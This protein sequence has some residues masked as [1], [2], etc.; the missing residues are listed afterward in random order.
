M[1]VADLEQQKVVPIGGGGFERSASGV[2]EQPLVTRYL[3]NSRLTASQ[4]A[5]RLAL[6]P[7]TRAIVGVLARSRDQVDR[8]PS[9][10]MPEATRWKRGSG[11]QP[12]DGVRPLLG[13]PQQRTRHPAEAR[14][15]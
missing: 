15:R 6:L 5:E 14:E 12:N 1:S 7:E 2:S 13:R 11:R 8:T 4:P 9:T 3:A 10:V